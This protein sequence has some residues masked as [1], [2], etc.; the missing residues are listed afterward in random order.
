M[1]GRT[2]NERPRRRIFLV[3]D[4]PGVRRGYE[5]LLSL[6][7]DLVVCGEAASADEAL[8]R[9]LD[10]RPDLA[11]VDLA[12]ER[13]NG[14][15]LIAHLHAQCPQVRVL[16][17]SMH[18][19]TGCIQTAQR[20]GAR[21]YLTKEECPDQLIRAVRRVLQGKCFLSHRASLRLNMCR[22]A[23]H[24]SPHGKPATETAR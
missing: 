13:S 3:E 23:E 14:L 2:S 17:V 9:I 8:A 20:A 16:V 1:D 18:D 4:H 22:S 19:E 5:L 6:E 7:P 10:S 11:I 21:G 12:L 15:D 24:R